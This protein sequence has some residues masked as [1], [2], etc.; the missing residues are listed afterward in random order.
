MDAPTTIRELDQQKAPDADTAPV[1]LQRTSLVVFVLFCFIIGGW[2][3]VLPWTFN[4][5]EHNGWFMAHPA[6]NAVLQQ[7][8]VRGV[9]SGLG[10]IDLWIAV[11]ELLHY[12]DYRPPAPGA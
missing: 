8:W 6:I 3:T 1:W 2:L 5:W 4:Y 11:S 10:L 12:R 9:I 7:G